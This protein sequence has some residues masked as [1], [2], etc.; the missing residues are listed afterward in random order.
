MKRKYLIICA[1]SIAACGP[2]SS[3]A[4]RRWSLPHRR[5][6]TRK[7]LTVRHRAGDNRPAKVTRAYNR[8]RGQSSRR[9]NRQARVLCLDRRYGLASILSTKPSSISSTK[10]FALALAG[11]VFASPGNHEMDIR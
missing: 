8:R 6:E 7:R 11:V 2:A 4:Q 1:A 9:R 3:P 10:Y 5:V